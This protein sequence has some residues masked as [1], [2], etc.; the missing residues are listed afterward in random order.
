MFPVYYDYYCCGLADSAGPLL[1]RREEEE[2]GGGLTAEGTA[3]A[4]P[5]S[6]FQYR[7]GQPGRAA[8]QPLNLR[9]TQRCLSLSH[10]LSSLSPGWGTGQFFI[11]R[12]PPSPSFIISLTDSIIYKLLSTGYSQ[13]AERRGITLNIKLGRA[14]L[15]LCDCDCSDQ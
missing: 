11:I 7:T 2:E 6:V 5:A 13:P 12:F 14:D 4:R 15:S 10:W 9:E 8:F 1:L 3:P